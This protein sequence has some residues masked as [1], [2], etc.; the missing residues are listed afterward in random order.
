MS[1]NFDRRWWPA[2][3]AAVLP[4]VFDLGTAL[5]SC[6]TPPR[7][8]ALLVEESISFCSFLFV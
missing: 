5:G 1:V 4:T 8:N 6:C 3:V 7:S 2:L